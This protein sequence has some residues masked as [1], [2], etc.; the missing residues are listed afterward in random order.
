MVGLSLPKRDEHSFQGLTLETELRRLGAEP[1]C[2]L[3]VIDLRTG[4]TAEW[5]RFEGGLVQELYD[6]AVLP[7]V[8]RPKALGFKTEATQRHVIVS[9]GG[10]VSSW[11]GVSSD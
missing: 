9:E 7:R 11:Q 3:L 10:M 4:D 6:V 5:L 8:V 1:R 2:G